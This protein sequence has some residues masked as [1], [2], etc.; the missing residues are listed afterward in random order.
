M[1][2][3]RRAAR[4]RGHMDDCSKVSAVFNNCRRSGTTVGRIE[5]PA[6]GRGCDAFS[7]RFT[8]G[9][10]IEVAL[11]G[12]TPCAVSSANAPAG[13]RG[14]STAS[15]SA[16][17]PWRRRFVSGADTA[18]AEPPHLV[19]HREFEARPENRILVSATLDLPYPLSADAPAVG[20]GV[21][22]VSA[23]QSRRH[24]IDCNR[25]VA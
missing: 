23:P 17:N 4:P 13:W 3:L 16:E 10:A 1:P 22:A 25:S 14:A 18:E 2:G 8:D 12:L 7:R 19:A 24:L 5:F 15:D 11:N 6:G 20:R 21:Y 9:W